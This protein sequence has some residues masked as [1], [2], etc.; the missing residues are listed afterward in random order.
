M[1]KG[2]VEIVAVYDRRYWNFYVDGVYTPGTYKGCFT[3]DIFRSDVRKHLAKMAGVKPQDLRF[4]VYS[5]FEDQMAAHRPDYD[6]N[7]YDDYSAFQN[8]VQTYGITPDAKAIKVDLET[9]EK[10]Y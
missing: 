9:L 6:A 3:E 4:T 10:Q 1:N 8:A 2:H 5:Q 7:D